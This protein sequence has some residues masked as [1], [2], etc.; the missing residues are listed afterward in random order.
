MSV[1]FSMFF[2][3][4]KITDMINVMRATPF[5]A[6]FN[7]TDDFEKSIQVTVN[8]SILVRT[9]ATKTAARDRLDGQPSPFSRA[10]KERER[11]CDRRGETSNPTMTD[12]SSDRA[13]IFL[14]QKHTMRTHS[15]SSSSS[16]RRLIL[17]ASEQRAMCD[18]RIR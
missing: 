13:S 3:S 2:F 17:S 7:R 16:S 18:V 5:G 1:I 8:V 4:I 6:P 15:S 12:P 11:V 14:N 10:L 9:L